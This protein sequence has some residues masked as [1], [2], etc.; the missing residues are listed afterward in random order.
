MTCRTVS[1]LLFL[2]SVSPCY[3][4]EL[5]PYRRVPVRWSGNSPR[6]STWCRV[7]C[8]GGAMTRHQ[9]K[10]LIPTQSKYLLIG[11]SGGS[12]YTEVLQHSK[13]RWC[14]WKRA[15]SPPRSPLGY[16]SAPRRPAFL[17]RSEIK[18]ANAADVLHVIGSKHVRSQS[19]VCMHTPWIRM[20][21]KCRFAPIAVGSWTRSW[22]HSLAWFCSDLL[23]CSSLLIRFTSASSGESSPPIK[24]HEQ[25]NLRISWGGT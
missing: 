14:S 18:T 7:C 13:E 4:T 16:H 21:S 8:P 6:R 22:S 3:S 23:T 15:E 25:T 20:K 5:W 19:H 9:W 12:G 11:C 17:S 10:G 24:K 2:P 1:L